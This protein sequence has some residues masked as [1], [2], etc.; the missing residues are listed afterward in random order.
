MLAERRRTSRF[1]PGL[2]VTAAFI[3]PGTITTASKAGAGFG[4][5]LAWA[6]LFSVVAAIV[7]QEMAARV[8]LVTRR[9]LGEA[10][11]SSIE[12]PALR[13]LA[14]ALVVAAIAFGNAAYETGNITGAAMGLEVLT[15]VSRPT[16]ALG[17]GLVAGVL[18]AIGSYKLIE[19][20]MIGLVVVMSVVFIITAVVIR[21][22]LG[23][24]ARGAFVPSLPPG[25]LVLTIAVIGTTVVPYNLFLHA[26]VVC[27]KWPADLPVSESLRESRRDTILAVALGGL[28]TLAVMTTASAMSTGGDF[29]GATDM[30]RQLEPLLGRWATWFFAIG[31]MAAGVTSAMTAPLAAAYATCGALGWSTALQGRRF[32]AVWATVLIAGVVFAVAAGG[33][34]VE[35]IIFAQA[36]NGIILPVVAVFLL[37]VVNRRTL[38]G[39]A[40]NRTTSNALG[41]LVVLVAA[42]LGV[43]KLWLLLTS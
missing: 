33:T 16:L 15:G 31:L 25:S 29:A 6:I 20:A 26:S 23:A 21:P 36:A 37:V 13:R 5:A 4:F 34:P 9:G 32:R 19:R 8:G 14:V 1:G 41:A 27:E 42:G 2:L 40:A 35:V 10:I 11:R 12:H 30:A 3:G 28:V 18:L 43:W 22:D 7:L 38:M 39:H 17:I 24:L